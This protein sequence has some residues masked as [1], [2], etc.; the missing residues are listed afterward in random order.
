M[1]L[2]ILVFVGLMGVT[3]LGLAEDEKGVVP[4][5]MEMHYLPVVWSLILAYLFL[6]F[7]LVFFVYFS[8]QLFF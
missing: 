6:V 8:C 5:V 2:W 7:L 3:G 4:V 1:L